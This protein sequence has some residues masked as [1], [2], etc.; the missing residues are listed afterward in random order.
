MGVLVTVDVAYFLCR[1]RHF[2]IATE[3]VEEHKTAVEV[4]AFEDKVGYERLHQAKLVALLVKFVVAVADEL[5]ASQQVLVGLPLIK[6]IVSLLGTANRVEH[7][8]VALAVYTFLKGLNVQTEV[9]L[10][11]GDILADGRQIIAL[12]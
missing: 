2:T 4:D 8:A 1:T 11:G 9:H 12:K 3:V 6:N 10:I 5:I 7:I